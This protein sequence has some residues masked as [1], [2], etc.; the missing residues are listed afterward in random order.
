[1]AN[2]KTNPILSTEIPNELLMFVIGKAIKELEIELLFDINEEKLSDCFK[3]VFDKV[4]P[5][6]GFDSNKLHDRNADIEGLT[7]KALEFVETAKY[8]MFGATF[9]E[10][11]FLAVS[12]SS[13]KFLKDRGENEKTLSKFLTYSSQVD[14]LEGIRRRIV[15]SVLEL[16]GSGGDTASKFPWN[17]ETSRLFVNTVDLLKPLWE[18]ISNFYKSRKGL[19]DRLSLLKDD[20]TYQNLSKA[21]NQEL[22]EKVISRM[23][24]LQ[25][26]PPKKN[27]SNRAQLTPLGFA[28]DHAAFE[29][30]VHQ[31]ND[32]HSTAT[33]IKNYHSINRQIR[34]GTLT[35]P[36]IIEYVIKL[37]TPS[38]KEN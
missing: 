18:Y 23:L 3:K 10:L 14:W 11:L 21:C 37:S 19:K 5:P 24:N 29:L 36:V 38:K 2:S 27:R 34:R 1:M 17:H 32:L 28:C 15:G 33:L 26:Q 6:D 31:G 9:L 22:I 13:E 35:D 4:M 25:S 8:K 12:S 16:R 20:K 30:C 7:K